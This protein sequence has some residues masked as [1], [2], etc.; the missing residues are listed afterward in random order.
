MCTR[1][2]QYLTLWAVN[3]Q[4]PTDDS[5]RFVNVKSSFASAKT[6]LLHFS[7]KLEAIWKC[8]AYSLEIKIWLAVKTKV[9]RRVPCT[10]MKIII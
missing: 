3:D 10:E 6:T 7:M 4:L 8:W 9:L 1:L 2:N 5:Q